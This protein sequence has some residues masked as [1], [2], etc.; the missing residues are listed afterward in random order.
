MDKKLKQE[1]MGIVPRTYSYDS[2]LDVFTVQCCTCFDQVM[3]YYHHIFTLYK[4]G[5]Q[6]P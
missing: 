6:H 1:N 4:R 2:W 3:L 5:K